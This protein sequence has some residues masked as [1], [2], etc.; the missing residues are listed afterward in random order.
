MALPHS[1]SGF[2]VFPVTYSKQATHIIYG[3]AHSSSKSIGSKAAVDVLPSERTLFLVNVPPDA[4]EREIM[5]FFKPFGLAEKVVFDQRVAEE[6]ALRAINEQETEDEEDDS[7]DENAPNALE[8]PTK[9][10]RR[11]GGEGE[12]RPEIQYMPERLVRPLRNS[13]RT[14]FLVFLDTS[15]LTSAL[16]QSQKPRQWP[17]SPEIRGL[18]NYR[19]KYVAARPALDAVKA[20]A[21]SIIM[22]FD[23]DEEQKKLASQYRKGEA[24]VDED[25]FTLVTRGGAYG[26]TVGGGVGVATKRFQE[27]GQTSESA[28]ARKK[29]KAAAVL[30]EGF[31]GFQ[32]HEKRRQGQ[33]T[34]SYT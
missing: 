15:S 29:K 31:Y 24:I 23:Y 2:H 9:K 1:I 27:T 21:E 4:T 26:Q 28:K 30:K 11:K 13:G 20:F 5:L 14:A 18:A 6:E 10:R 32:R 17:S 19:N 25:G 12:K 8:G 3:K 33:L 16:S 34:L 7:E 22:Q